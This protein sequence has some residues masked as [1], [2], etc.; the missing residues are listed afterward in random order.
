MNGLSLVKYANGSK[1]IGS[2]NIYVKELITLQ[3]ILHFANILIE[4]LYNNNNN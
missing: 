1:N 2:V 4:K 3:R